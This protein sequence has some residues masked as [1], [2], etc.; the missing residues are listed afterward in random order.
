M[1]KQS[2]SVDYEVKYSLST[3]NNVVNQDDAIAP[4]D[5]LYSCTAEDITKGMLI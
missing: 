1:F 3:H 5:I 4:T 2:N